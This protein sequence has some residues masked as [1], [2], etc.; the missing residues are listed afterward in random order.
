MLLRHAKYTKTLTYSLMHMLV[1]ISVAYAVSGN[2]AV[3]LG[4]GLLE[5]LVQTVFYHLHERL[6]AR[7]DT[8]SVLA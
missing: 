6:W 7:A 8:K 2:W 5:P 3:A 4:I 1:A